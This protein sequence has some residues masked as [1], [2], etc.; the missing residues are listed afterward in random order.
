MSFYRR[1]PNKVNIIPNRD[2]SEEIHAQTLENF[3]KWCNIKLIW[4][5]DLDN[6]FCCHCGYEPPPI[7]KQKQKAEK[8]EWGDI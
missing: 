5:E 7:R 3:C 8:Q 6:Y 1:R 4:R 2:E